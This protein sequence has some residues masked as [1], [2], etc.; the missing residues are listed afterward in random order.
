MR[1]EVQNGGLRKVTLVITTC[2]NRKRRPV[3]DSLYMHA[4][5]QASLSAVAAEWALRMNAAEDRFP[6]HEIYGG[7]GFQEAISASE[8]LDARLMVVSAGLGLVYASTRVPPYACTVLEDAPDSV[9]GRVVE[10]FSVMEWWTALKATSP[11]AVTLNDALVGQDGLI[12]AALSEAYMELISGDLVAL[13]E[14]IQSRLRLFTRA[15]L[16]RV[17]PK[18]RSFVMPYD[19]RL[20]GPDSPIPGTRSDFAARA[21]RHFADMVTAGNER[22]S[23]ADHATSVSA[24]LEGWGFPTKVERVRYDD[25]AMLNLLRAH[26]GDPAGCSLRRFRDEFGVACEQSRFSALTSVVRAERA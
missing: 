25:A 4:L 3:P 24:A 6:A 12:C 2:T 19:D 14:E 16:E 18:L 9:G 1:T 11:F 17:P 21:L 15:P 13:P 10:E 26:W 20:D 23:V 8:A 22:W 7:R 5:P